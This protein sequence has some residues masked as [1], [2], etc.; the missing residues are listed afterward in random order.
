MGSGDNYAIESR[1]RFLQSQ[2]SS[3]GYE[4]EFAIDSLPLLECLV[5]DL[6]QTTDTMKHYKELS[7][8]CLQVIYPFDCSEKHIGIGK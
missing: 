6:L 4:H 3:L 8:G 2:L 7:R 5:A 1:Y